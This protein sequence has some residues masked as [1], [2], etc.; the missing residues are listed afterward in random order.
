MDGGKAEEGNRG[1]SEAAGKKEAAGG[2][3][4]TESVS[5]HAGLASSAAEAQRA[6]ASSEP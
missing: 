1:W 4:G 2:R 6:A 5:P 3:R